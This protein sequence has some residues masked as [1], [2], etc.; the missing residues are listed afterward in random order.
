MSAICLSLVTNL[1][2]ES[3]PQF[4]QIILLIPPVLELLVSIGLIVSRWNNGKRHLV[5]AAE[6]FAF[7]V[8]A[9]L[10]FL[11]HLLPQ[12]QSHL[13]VFKVLDIIVGEFGFA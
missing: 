1:R 4:E 13:E 5:L 11:A 2:C 7:L 12:A 9:V 3:L 6:G 10:D 8:L